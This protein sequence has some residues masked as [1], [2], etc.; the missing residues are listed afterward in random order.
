M[1]NS[2]SQ[3]IKKRAL[4][5]EGDKLLVAVSGGVDSM[6]LWHL[7]DGL[8]FSYG[9]AHCNFK[10]RD[11]DSDGDEEF[12]RNKATELDVGF[13]VKSFE[14]KVYAQEHGISTQMA[15][16]DLRYA[17][18]KELSEELGYTKLLTAHHAD[19]DV[20]T[21]FLNLARG[22]SIKGLKGMEF[23]QNEIVRPLLN[24]SKY[25]I[26][27]FAELKKI[28]WRDDISNSETYYKRN[29]IRHQIIPDF[30]ELNP[31][32]LRT[33]K[34]N[35]A[36]NQ[37]VFELT[38]KMIDDLKAEHLVKTVKGWSL[39]KKFL[40]QQGIGPYILSQ[41]LNEFE[42]TFTQC[43]DILEGFK[44]SPGKKFRSKDY[45]LLID[46]ELLFVQKI[47]NVE[48][49]KAAVIL[50]EEYLLASLPMKYN[51]RILSKEGLSIDKSPKNAMLDYDKLDF[52]MELRSWELGD[53]FYPLGMKG[54]KLISDLL[55]DLKVPVLDK[56]SIHVLSSNDKI[57]WVV[58][59][60]V[61]EEFKVDKNT[62]RVVHFVRNE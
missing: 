11:E 21:Y 27:N 56:E 45:Q 8:G 55:I 47:E 23:V 60:R 57:A 13:H 2:F 34:R 10:L 38:K 51:V 22:T 43:E 54:Q 1:Q 39:S 58:G 3:L 20:E 59:L 19:D 14:T 31:E 36:K 33:M 6:V 62:K 37:E 7:L 35:M 40:N 28:E 15:A 24:F 49:R 50:N 44:G 9:I 16:R 17:W 12:V 18:F 41:L 4:F 46:R 26:Q 25:E 52:P 32:F 42:F 53:R 29:F 5:N 48:G 30:K 61:S